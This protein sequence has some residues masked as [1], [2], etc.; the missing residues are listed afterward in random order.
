MK[1]M[2]VDD[3]QL[4]RQGII[5]K[6]QMSGLPVTIIAEARDGVEALKKLHEVEV[7]IVI[8]DIRMPH[9][10]GLSLMREAYLDFPELQFIVIS[11]Y[12]EF[13]Y[14]R[15]AI[16]YGV[17]DYLLKPVDKE[18][19]KES[20]LR[21][22]AIIERRL[23]QS[24]LGEQYKHLQISNGESLR[25]QVLSKLIQYGV[26][27][28]QSEA[29]RDEWLENMKLNCKHFVVVVF[30]IQTIHLPHLSFR[31]EDEKLLWFAVQNIISIVLESSGRAGVLFRHAM[32]ENELVYVLGGESPIKAEELR[33]ELEEIIGGIE[34]HLKLEATI[35]CG[36]FVNQMDII[37]QSYQQAK[38]AL[39]NKV[40]Y[41]HGRTY[42]AD[43]DPVKSG[44]HFV[45]SR[46][47][48]VLLLGCLGECNVGAI[49]HWINQRVEVFAASE[50]VLFTHLESFCVEFHLL[51]RK[52]LLTQTSIPEWIIGDLDDLLAWLHGMKHWREIP[53]HLID[54]VQNMI[55]HLSK[56]RQS[57]DYNLIDE[58][59]LYIDHSLHE[60][61]TL[62]MIANRFF[63]NSSYF[64]RRFKMWF[65]ESV[66]NYLTAARIR[67]SEQ[68]LRDPE[69]KIQQ[70]AELVGFND[71]AYFSSV[72]RKL[73]G[74][75]PNQF[76]GL[77]ISSIQDQV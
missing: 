50:Q 72:F 70:I 67:K 58:V 21:I 33:R 22:I 65:G 40:I 25:E 42:L 19:L 29:V 46:E 44:I 68:L 8:T 53:Q 18:E 38:Q 56:L 27:S 59:K 32:L 35:G 20:I 37:Q 63:F 1:I 51:L 24:S 7:D 75:T 34:R 48:E 17:T 16:Q 54:V 66:V 60:P 71:A 10:D 55:G 12:G 6:I 64:S 49:T 2:I 26:D 14:A 36:T 47:D 23:E 4:I 45:I 77:S 74:M 73:T 9:M 31:E 61:L 57:P 5:K 62:Q 11:G 52:Y 76:R 39:R 13:E 41:G 69:L 3:E 15:K 43:T 28:G 30:V